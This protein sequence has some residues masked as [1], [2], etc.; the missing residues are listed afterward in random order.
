MHLTDQRKSSLTWLIAS[1]PVIMLAMFVVPYT[2]LREV[3]AWY[4]SALFW[5]VMTVAV[6]AVNVM[7]SAGWDDEYETQPERGQL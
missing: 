3:D 4:G 6:I 5:T 7:V 2:L 1:V